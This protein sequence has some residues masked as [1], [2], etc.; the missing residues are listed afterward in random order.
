MRIPLAPAGL[1][2]MLIMTLLF[3][4]VAV[5][6]LTGAILG[7]APG[8]PIGVL[9]ALAW[10]AG[11]AF[12]RDPHRTPPGDPAA[13]GAPAD[14]RIVET[15]KLAHH[16][17]IDGPASRISIFLSVLDVHVN[18]S[19]CAGRVRAV[20]YQ[21]GQYLDA[22]DPDSGR[23]NEA[24]TIIIDP[25]EPHVGPIVVRQIAGLIARRIV[26]DIKPGDRLETGQRIGMI[27]FGSRTELIVPGHVNYQTAVEVGDRAVGGETVMA[28][29]TAVT[30]SREPRQVLA[31]TES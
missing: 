30:S 26:C 18:R 19:P 28:R 9:F 31:A 3:G 16:E 15:A 7:Y 4:G 13:L 27:K 6:A 12:F 1:R 2:E 23:L 21:P 14:G 25:D 11:L 29:R 8:W 24:N 5:A 22:R 20:R 17:E 10:L